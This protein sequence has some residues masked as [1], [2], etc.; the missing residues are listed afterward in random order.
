MIFLILYATGPY[1]FI[2]NDGAKYV[3]IAIFVYIGRKFAVMS[4]NQI[5]FALTVS[6]AFVGFYT[7]NFKGF[8]YL[9]VWLIGDIF[10]VILATAL[11]NKIV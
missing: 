2:K 6:Q 9:F 7:C 4:G 1:S 5:N 11:Y 3:F 10:G 8:L